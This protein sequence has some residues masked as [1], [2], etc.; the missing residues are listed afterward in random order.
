MPDSLLRRQCDVE[1]GSTS[2]VP[3]PI[4]RRQKLVWM[5]ILAVVHRAG[6]GNYCARL[7]NPSEIDWAWL[8]RFN[9]K[10]WHCYKHLYRALQSI[11]RH[12]ITN[13]PL[14]RRF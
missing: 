8:W 5:T 10:K 1:G 4:S 6:P 14:M 2:P 7:N 12:L 11:L 13:N 3:L 9:R